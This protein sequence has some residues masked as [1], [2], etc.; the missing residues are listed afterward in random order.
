VLGDVVVVLVR[1]AVFDAE[2]VTVAV[3]E[4][5]AILKVGVAVELLLWLPVTLPVMDWVAV[6]VEVELSESVVDG[7][8]VTVLRD[9]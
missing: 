8:V 2:L 6:D 9:E 5:V 4:R 3:L 1:K 7:V